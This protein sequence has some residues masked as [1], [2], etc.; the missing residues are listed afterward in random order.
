VF[1][2]NGFVAIAQGEITDPAQ[3]IGKW[4]VAPVASAAHGDAQTASERQQGAAKGAAA[5][6][7]QQ[8]RDAGKLAGGEANIDKGRNVAVAEFP[9]GHGM[10]ELRLSLIHEM[11]DIWRFDIPDNVDGRT[12]HD[13]LLKHLNMLGDG[14]NWP[15]DVNEGYRMVAHHVLMALYNVDANAGASQH[16]GHVNQ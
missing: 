4:P 2:Q 13:S 14:S 11:P 8:A 12:L 10:P 15:S 6:T 5:D 7:A 16:Q 9:A 1:G 3:L